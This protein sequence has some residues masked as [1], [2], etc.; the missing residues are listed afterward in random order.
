VAEQLGDPRSA[1]RRLAGGLRD[2]DPADDVAGAV[3]DGH[4]AA[5]QD[6][7]DHLPR[8][9][10]A[11]LVVEIRRRVEVPQVGM[12]RRV[13]RAVRGREVRRR[14]V[15]AGQRDPVRLGPGGRRGVPPQV[16]RVD[17]RMPQRASARGHERTPERLAAGNAPAAQLLDNDRYNV[18]Y[19]YARPEREEVRDPTVA[20]HEPRE[21]HAVAPDEHTAAGPPRVL[22]DRHDAPA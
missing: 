1:E 4:A 7:A 8:R 22:H 11:Q 21:H 2:E 18:L 20:L 19:R 12:V 10:R 3:L 14:P 9:D 17:V 5:R 16:A 15:G 6:R 13:R